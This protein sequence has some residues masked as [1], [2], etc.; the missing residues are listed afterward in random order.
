[1]AVGTALRSVRSMRNLTGRPDPLER[2]RGFSGSLR[3]T[4]RVTGPLRSTGA[5]RGLIWLGMAAVGISGCAW[6]PSFDSS[7]VGDGANPH[8]VAQPSGVETERSGLSADTTR[9]FPRPSFTGHIKTCRPARWRTEPT[10]MVAEGSEKHLVRPATPRQA[11]VRAATVNLAFQE[12]R[13]LHHTERAGM[14][15]SWSAAA[16]PTGQSY[17]TNG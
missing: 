17:R 4:A 6:S 7:L 9:S 2:S 12:F 16:P 13:A 11:T 5:W 10:R 8:F 14:T 1:M 15:S 3:W